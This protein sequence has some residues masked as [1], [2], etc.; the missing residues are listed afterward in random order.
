MRAWLLVALL[1][2]PPGAQAARLLPRMAA[3]PPMTGLA[4]W[5]GRLHDGRL[6]ANGHRFRALGLSAASLALPLGTRV[7]VT[8]L[9]NGRS[10]ELTITD[11]G[12]RKTCLI[13]VSLGAA[14]A[15]GMVHSGL[16]LVR[17]EVLIEPPPW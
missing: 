8:R 6:M 16:A 9:A 15:L 4:S 13:D 17:I 12:P 3:P 2:L 11:R 10:I 7:R 5:Y 14:R 1:T